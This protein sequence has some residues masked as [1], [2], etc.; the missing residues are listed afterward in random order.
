MPRG[1][2]SGLQ[3]LLVCRVGS[4][5]CGLPLEHVVETMR[6]LSPE[7]V[8]RMPPFVRGVSVI[9]GRPLPVLDARALLGARSDASAGRSVTVKVGERQLA[10][11]VDQVLGIHALDAAQSS[12]LPPVLGDAGDSLEA[13][14]MLDAELLLVL[15]SARLLSEEQFALLEAQST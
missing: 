9:R 15:Q 14:G 5:L 10:L 7:P 4:S 8:P 3:R 13:L 6:P 2:G 12:Q 11:L 1:R